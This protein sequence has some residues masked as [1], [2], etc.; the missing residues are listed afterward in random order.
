MDT[1]GPHG[2]ANRSV[3]LFADAGAAFEREEYALA[4]RSLDLL[5]ASFPQ[6]LP[7]CLLRANAYLNLADHDRSV[8]E[9]QVALQLDPLSAEAHLILGMNFLKLGRLEVAVTQLRRAAYLSPALCMIQFQL[10]EAY[11]A[12]GMAEQS[13]RA[14]RNA[15]SALES[16]AEWHVRV[17]SGGF[18]R[19]ALKTF[20]ERMLE[21]DV[22]SG[23]R[24]D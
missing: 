15:L 24:P 3:S 20:C 13:Q 5:L 8:A 7:G 12:L 22:T 1:T 23:D 2:S 4:C 10:A 14:Y 19:A 17:Y 9:C 16:T 11:R 21:P 18:G 6:H